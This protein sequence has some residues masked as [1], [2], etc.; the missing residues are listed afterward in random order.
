MSAHLLSHFLFP[1]EPTVIPVIAFLLPSFLF[2]LFL[3]RK[4]RSYHG[5]EVPRDHLTAR[6]LSSFPCLVWLVLRCLPISSLWLLFSIENEEGKKGQVRVDRQ[7]P[8]AL[9]HTVQLSLPF[10]IRSGNQLL[11][12]KEGSG[13][14]VSRFLASSV[15]YFYLK[16]KEGR[17]R[18]N[19]HSGR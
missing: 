15:L 2:L 16:N 1:D 10:L 14:W 5:H 6:P 7:L 13:P 4:G 12:K 9:V 17:D 18:R 19:H 8:W 3:K 11:I